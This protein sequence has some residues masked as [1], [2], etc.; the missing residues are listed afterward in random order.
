MNFIGNHPFS[1]PERVFPIKVLSYFSFH[2]RGTYQIK[3]GKMHS[4]FQINC[5]PL[6]LSNLKRQHYKSLKY[7]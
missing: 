2:R 4:K 1:Y 3:K 5:Q 6:S 7:G